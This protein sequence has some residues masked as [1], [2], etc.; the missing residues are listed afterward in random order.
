M[1]APAPYR[2]VTNARIRHALPATSTSGLALRLRGRELRGALRDQRVLLADEH[3]ALLAHVDDHL[4][5]AAEGVGQ[6]A[7]VAHGDRRGPGPVTHPE[8]GD[9]ALARIPRDHLAGELIALAGARRGEQLAGRARLAGGAE[10]RPD[11]RAGEQHGDG[12]RDHQADA[13]LV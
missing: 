4:A 12:E 2:H 13:A 6:L 5:T 11:E 3:A 10:A 8:V 1:E 7:V 9:G